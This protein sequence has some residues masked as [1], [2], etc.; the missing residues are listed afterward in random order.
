MGTVAIIL[1]NWNGYTDTAICLGSLQKLTY[2]AFKVIVVD[3][4]SQDDSRLHIKK[5]FPEVHLIE[6]TTNE[7]FTGG[8][9]RGIEYAL[10]EGYDYVMLLNNDTIVPPDLINHLLNTYTKHERVG[11]IQPGITFMDQPD[12]IWNAGGLWNRWIGDSKTMG[13]CEPVASWA[14][15]VSLVDWLTGCCLLMSTDFIRKVGA[16]EERYFAYYEDV[17]WSLRAKKL[18]YQLLLDTN[19]WIQHKAGA[20]GKTKSKE[21]EGFLHPILHYY[22]VRNHLW[23][24]RQHPQAVHYV[25]ASIFQ[26]LKVIAYCIYF[27]LRG[28]FRKLKMTLKGVFDGLKS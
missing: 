7:G 24:I 28:R 22:N 12:K 27:F 16:L 2:G 26:F 9:N 25:T 18:G 8:N 10:D 4:A 21:R 15:E 6:S 5:Y 23:L 20:S 11:M 3:N 13:Y 14:N 17:E 19:I 1:V